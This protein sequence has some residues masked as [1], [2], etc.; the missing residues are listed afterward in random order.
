MLDHPLQRPGT[1]DGVVAEPRHLVDGGLRAVERD[2]RLVR[3]IDQ[4]LHLKLHDPADVL[5][6]ERVEDDRLVDAVEKLGEKAG[7]ERLLH[8]VADL[9]L[10]APLL[11]DLLNRLAAHVAR[12]HH[13][14]VGEVD[15][16]PEAVAEPSVVEHL[17]EDVEDV[18][19]GLLHLVEQDDGIR[20]TPD[21]LGETPAFLV[22]HVAWGRT[23]Q[24]GDR[25]LLHKLAHVDANHGV[26]VVKQ[27]LCECLAQL[28]LPDARGA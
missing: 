25:V 23:D 9:L 14:R 12:H 17:E 13:D 15:R 20:P 26:F 21:R 18:A 8:G 5:L 1:V 11:R 3:L 19:V 7:G 24:P 6:I 10:A 2:S 22:A 4:P 16:V 28:R 27:H